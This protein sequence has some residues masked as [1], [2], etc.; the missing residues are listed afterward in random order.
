MNSFIYEFSEIKERFA[1]VKYSHDGGQ[2]WD[3]F[4]IKVKDKVLRNHAI[5]NLPVLSAD[6][7]DVAVAV[8]VADWLSYRKLNGRPADMIIKLPVRSP[9]LLSSK[10]IIEKLEDL[11]AWFTEDHWHFEFSQRS[12]MRYVEKQSMLP[13]EINGE[14][15]VALWSGGLDSLAGLYNRYRSEPY[16][17]YVLC[18]S[19]FNKRVVG[20]QRSVFESLKQRISI[21]AALWQIPFYLEY[22]LHISK[23][24]YM[25]SRGFTFMLVGSA[26]TIALNQRKLHVYENGVGAINLKYYKFQIGLDHTR[27]VHPISLIRTSEFLSVLLGEP[28]EIVN[29][30]IFR[31]KA[32]MCKPLVE[33]NLENLI[34]ETQTCDSV[35]RKEQ[36]QCGYC[37]SCLLRRQALLINN[38]ND[39]TEYVLTHGKTKDENPRL[40]LDAMMHQVK[41]LDDLLNRKQDLNQIWYDL[42][43]EY[44]VLEKMAHEMSSKYNQSKIEIQKKLVAMYLVYSNE[45]H[46][47][48]KI[49]QNTYPEP[50]TV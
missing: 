6:L 8:F 38:V 34:F 19:G 29:P 16:V 5:E 11:L 45:W 15:E 26:I 24:S 10:E 17:K 30:F 20:V 40:H 39:E 37:S 46:S 27:S 50:V 13:F 28:F 12:S 23:H 9:E 41:V 48:H 49:I 18:G 4:K 1:R 35:H 21:N 31:T 25:R 42:V 14:I 32:Q 36:S 44:P 43:N 3:T 47:A 7:I 33:D 2:N 22:S